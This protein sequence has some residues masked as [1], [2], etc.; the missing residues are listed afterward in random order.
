MAIFVDLDEE[1]ELTSTE[2]HL[3]HNG[4]HE[5][6]VTATGPKQWARGR[7][8]DNSNSSSAAV[9]SG[10]PTTS[11][12]IPSQQSPPMTPTPAT[13]FRNGMTEALGCYP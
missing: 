7:D 4:F 10:N 6:P 8:G 13:S 3:S 1:D 12:S 5:L 2:N 11:T 9:E